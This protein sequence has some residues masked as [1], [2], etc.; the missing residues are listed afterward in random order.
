MQHRHIHIFVGDKVDT[1]EG[2]GLVDEVYTFRDRVVGMREWE[3]A[4]FADKCFR[5]AGIDYRKTWAE[6]FVMVRGRRRRFL[7]VQI[8]VLEGR[9]VQKVGFQS[10]PKSRPADAGGDAESG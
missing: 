7:A 10:A 6:V 5:E 2:V 8:K 4:E 9:D 3:A 1:P